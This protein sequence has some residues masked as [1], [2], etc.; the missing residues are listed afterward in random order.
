[1]IKIASGIVEGLRCVH[2]NNVTH[3]DLKPQN[4]LMFGSTT[5]DMIPKIADFGVSKVIDTAMMKHTGNV[6]TMW[7]MA[8]EVKSCEEYGFTADIY[9]LATVLFEIFNEQLISDTSDK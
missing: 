1:M 5:E 7:Y 3:R 8:P 6:G 2:S 4:I 9:S